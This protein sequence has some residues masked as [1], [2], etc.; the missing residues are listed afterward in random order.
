MKN[1]LLI[2]GATGLVGGC[3]LQLAVDE[4]YFSKITILSR[5]QIRYMNGIPNFEQHITDFSNDGELRKIVQAETVVCAIGTTINKAGSKENFYKTDHDL[6]LKLAKIAKENGTKNFILVSSIGASEKS[7]I[8]YSRVKGELERDVKELGFESL[9]ILRPSL[10]L[11]KRMDN[12]PK[13]FMGKIF[14]VPFSALLPDKYKPIK[15]S[16]LAR[17]IVFLAKSPLNGIKIYEGRDLYLISSNDT[18]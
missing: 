2:L 3:V 13:E 9:V 15:A 4:K 1:S 17:K 18:V 8:F 12:R 10:L 5:R 11:G 6:P 16:Q 7:R 14:S